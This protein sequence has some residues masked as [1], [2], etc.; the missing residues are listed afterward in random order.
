MWHCSLPFIKVSCGLGLMISRLLS[1]GAGRH[2]LLFGVVCLCSCRNSVITTQPLKTGS[3]LC[4][5]YWQGQMRQDLECLFSKYCSWWLNSSDLSRT[6]TACIDLSNREFHNPLQS[7][8]FG[9]SFTVF[10]RVCV[11]ICVCVTQECSNAKNVEGKMEFSVW[12]FPRQTAHTLFPPLLP[13]QFRK[14]QISSCF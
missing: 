6:G 8:S 3:S 7:I 4:A 10:P 14:T 1:A 11:W 5:V 13:K 2:V 12:R 9:C